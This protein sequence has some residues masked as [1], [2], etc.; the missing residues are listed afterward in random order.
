MRSVVII[1][2][3]VLSLL[4]Q[5]V[6]SVLRAL[7]DVAFWKFGLMNSAV[8]LLAVAGGETRLRRAPAVR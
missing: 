1:V 7:R 4:V 3:R 6:T 5:A 2:S 8:V